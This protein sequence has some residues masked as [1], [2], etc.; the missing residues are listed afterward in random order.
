MGPGDG[1]LRPDSGH[2]RLLVLISDRTFRMVHRAVGD[3]ATR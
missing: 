1:T 3:G 2:S